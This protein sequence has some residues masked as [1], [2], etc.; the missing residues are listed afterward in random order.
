MKFV[1]C[2]AGAN[3]PA[4]REFDIQ[5]DA[6]IEEGR[7]VCATG[8]VADESVKNGILLGV[9]AET[10]SGKADILNPRSDGKRIRVNV[11]AGAVY[12]AKAKSLTALTGCTAT[13]F[14]CN[15]TLFSSAV[16]S[17]VLVLRSKADGSTNTD[18]IGAVRTVS[19]CAVSS[20][21]ATFTVS[22]G[23]VPCAGDVYEYYPALGAEVYA[24]SDG[25]G[26]APVNASTD[27]KLKV[28]GI[29]AEKGEV[30]VTLKNL[31]FA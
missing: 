26:F 29:D 5:P 22:S 8:G 21:K 16:T 2:A 25:T 9:A 15:S 19:A 7:V 27:I 20:G 10:H 30:F 3:Q 28:V 1:F 24:D 18:A 6:C 11:T 17:G 13:A 14:S 31:L 12:S 23:G 4:I